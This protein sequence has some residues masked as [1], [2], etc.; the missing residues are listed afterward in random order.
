MYQWIPDFV[1]VINC[2]GICFDEEVPGIA[3]EFGGGVS[4]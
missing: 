1:S 3:I 4:A 2:T